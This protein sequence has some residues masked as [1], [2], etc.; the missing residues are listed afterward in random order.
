MQDAAGTR[1]DRERL[2]RELATVDEKQD[3]LLDLKIAGD[4]TLDEFK[5]MM[6]KTRARK[7]QLEQ[8]LSHLSNRE[9]LSEQMAQQC[10]QL[11]KA[12]SFKL[13]ELVDG[14]INRDF[15]DCFIQRIDVT[16]GSDNTPELEIQVLTVHRELKNRGSYWSNVRARVS[17]T[18]H[19]L[20]PGQPERYGPRDA[21][22]IY[23]H[24]M[25]L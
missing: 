11:R 12:L 4:L 21:H 23:R 19:D 18:N 25:S 10:Q 1:Q 9:D 24:Q 5:R 17:G 15:V 8:E 22:Y 7:A 2:N 6:E 20:P 14:L 13:S 16:S 3:Q